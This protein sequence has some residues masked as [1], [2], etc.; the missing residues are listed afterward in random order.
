MISIFTDS[1]SILS[2]ALVFD[3]L[4]ADLETISDDE[5]RRLE[6]PR[7]KIRLALPVIIR[8]AEMAQYCKRVNALHSA[9]FRKWQVANLAAFG[10]VPENSDISADWHLY[11]WNTRAAEQLKNLG[12]ASFTLSPELPP[13]KKIAL[14]R[15]CSDSPC[16]IEPAVI[17]WQDTPLM[18]SEACPIAAVAGKCAHC[19]AKNETILEPRRRG[20]DVIIHSRN[21][22]NTVTNATPL[23]LRSESDAL[24]AAGCR[25]WRYDFRFRNYTAD[26]VAQII[27]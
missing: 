6:I 20:D 3:E 14:L 12:C 1:L 18:I 11:A 5:L 27:A 25:R 17:L 26:E 4:V 24:H 16:G 23:D 19:H 22:R 8:A 13:E 21:C 9:G 2:P 15:Q 7:G 10:I